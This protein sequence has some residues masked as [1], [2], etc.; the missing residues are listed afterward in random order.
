M[1][2]HSNVPVL[3][4]APAACSSSRREELDGS[5]VADGTRNAIHVGATDQAVDMELYYHFPAR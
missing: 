2:Y 1:M 3:R 5:V 4:D